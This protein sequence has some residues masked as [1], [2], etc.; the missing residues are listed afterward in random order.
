MTTPTPRAGVLQTAHNQVLSLW[1][2]RAT[3][4]RTLIDNFRVPKYNLAMDNCIFC[5]IVRGEE[6]SWKVCEDEYAYAFLCIH[7]ATKWHTLVIP[8]RHY[9]NAFDIPEDDLSHM[10][11]VVKKVVTLFES[12]LGIKNLQIIN[13]SGSEAQQDVFHLHFHIVPRSKGDGQD[14]HWTLHPEWQQEF[15]QQLASLAE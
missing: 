4:T 12:K 5:Q 6:K 8:K 1:H 7:P 11:S 15:D 9:V 2:H 10:M 13:S 14:V 3:G